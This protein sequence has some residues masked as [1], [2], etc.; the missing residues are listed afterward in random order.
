M[1]AFLALDLSI[2]STGYALWSRGMAWPQSGTWELAPHVD[3]AGRAFVRLHQ[4]LLALHRGN[5][6][7]ELVFE[8]AVP[9]HQ[10]HGNTNA[11][12]LAA[13]AGLAAHAMSFA[14]AIGCRWRSVSIRAWRKHFIGSVPRGT[15]T[16]DLKH[17][18]MSRC[19]E[20]GFE[21][22]KHDEGEAIGLLDYQLG[23]AG[24]VPPWRQTHVLQREMT[25]ATD[26]ARA[27]P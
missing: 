2:R 15:K 13:A 14:E 11:V 16:P 6:I 26:G 10:L 25:P 22:V 24:I 17:M 18:T 7:G 1:S 12:T 5:S 9:A 27:A 19:R 4:H 21:P 8:E 3:H 20:L 23:V